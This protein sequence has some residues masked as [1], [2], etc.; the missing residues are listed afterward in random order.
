MAAMEIADS[1]EGSQAFITNNISYANDYCY[2][3]E[4]SDVLNWD[5]PMT[6]EQFEEFTT[7]DKEV[8]IT[9]LLVL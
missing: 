4:A 5:M 9:L 7:M 3:Y 8:L 6:K 1:G 2:N